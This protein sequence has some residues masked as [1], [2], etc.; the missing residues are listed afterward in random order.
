MLKSDYRCHFFKMGNSVP[1]CC[2]PYS[3]LCITGPT[4]SKV[5]QSGFNQTM[6]WL[7]PTTT[8]K[9]SS[10]EESNNNNLI[11]K[12]LLWGDLCCPHPRTGQLESGLYQLTLFLTYTSP[13]WY[14][15]NGGPMMRTSRPLDT[16]T[17]Y[18]CGQ[19]QGPP[20][21]GIRYLDSFLVL[22]QVK[23]FFGDR[24]SLSLSFLPC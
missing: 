20:R 18:L 16:T 15:R 11:D 2:S 1:V 10:P 12:D 8:I 22:I 13:T 21:A 19:V 24:K 14:I 6:A 3:W 17:N 5:T 9:R 23:M 4:F 7:W